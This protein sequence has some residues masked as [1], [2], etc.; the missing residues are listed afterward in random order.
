MPTKPKVKIILEPG[1][2]R[3]YNT[4]GGQLIWR[5]Y[6]VV[7]VTGATE[8]QVLD[9]LTKVEVDELIADGIQVVINRPSGAR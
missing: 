7:Q 6:K 2:R 1:F 5:T 8:P 3:D 4:S 9:D